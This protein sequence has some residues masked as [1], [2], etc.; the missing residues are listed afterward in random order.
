M[1]ISELA[2]RTG[3]AEVEGVIIDVA[4]PRAFNKF[5]KEGRVANAKLQDDSG[6]VTLTLWNEQ[7][8][9][10]K[11]GTKVRIKNG[12]VSEWQGESQL[13]TGKFGTMEI[14]SASDATEEKKPAA[15]HATPPG[16]PKPLSEDDV[17]S[18]EELVDEDE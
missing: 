4:A 15:K 8:D 3:N 18:E 12:W 1:K 14:V 13:S 2:P 5:G 7:I 17:A 6:T 10:V 11:V 16:K 9:Q